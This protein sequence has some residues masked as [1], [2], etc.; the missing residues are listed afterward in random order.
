MRIN[1]LCLPT[2]LFVLF[3]LLI[4]CED[5]LKY[6]CPSLP[7]YFKSNET[8]ALFLETAFEP[9]YGQSSDRLKK[10]NSDINIFIDGVPTRSRL[11]E[12]DTVI[13]ELNKLSTYIPINKV[14][15]KAEANLILYLGSM[16]N[17]V[18]AV[19]PSVANIALG[20]SGFAAISWNSSNEIIRASACV[21][22]VNFT[23]LLFFKHVLRE[24]LAQTLGIVNDT[25][26]N[27]KS[28]FYQLPNF[29]ITYSEADKEIIS[30]LLGDELKAG[31]C[32]HEAL[33]IID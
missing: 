17:Y 29:T 28:I 23:G 25:N 11:A 7:E 6:S 15:S 14:N 18:T 33:K 13:K 31:M 16:E 8:Q 4:S 19:E 3:G 12:V 22:I 10:W 5:N 27:E 30:Y 21:D 24:E 32:K 9:E 26:N 20:N 2:I 1:N